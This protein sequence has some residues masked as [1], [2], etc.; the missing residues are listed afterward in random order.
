M[1]LKVM[2]NHRRPVILARVK[3]PRVLSLI[4]VIRMDSSKAQGRVVVQTTRKVIQNPKLEMQREMKDVRVSRSRMAA[5][6][7]TAR[8]DQADR[9]LRV[10]MMPA[11]VTQQA[12]NKVLLRVARMVKPALQKR[13][14]AVL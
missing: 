14:M 5:I 10:A 12:H 11:L 6:R 4:R 1:I 9:S 8:V 3:T 13:L 2:G 7:L